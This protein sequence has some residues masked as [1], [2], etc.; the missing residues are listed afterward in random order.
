MGY[1]HYRLAKDSEERVLRAE[2]QI[3][4]SLA[5]ALNTKLVVDAT[6]VH[7]ILKKEI[8]AVWKDAI[9]TGMEAAKH[10]SKGPT[11]E[12]VK[13]SLS[14]FDEVKRFIGD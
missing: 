13:D 10:L 3:E 9:L 12:E 11:F 4:M 8:K 5:R 14:E 6:Y 7:G 2:K 1:D